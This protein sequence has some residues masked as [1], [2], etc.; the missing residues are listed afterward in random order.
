MTKKIVGFIALFLIIFGLCFARVACRIGVT[1]IAVAITS[2]VLV[3]S[4][5]IAAIIAGIVVWM[6]S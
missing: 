5:A 1:W 2:G 3:F 6:N 4:G